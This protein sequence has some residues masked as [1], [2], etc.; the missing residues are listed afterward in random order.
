MGTGTSGIAAIAMVL[1][2]LGAQIGVLSFPTT[3][4]DLRSVVVTGGGHVVICNHYNGEQF[5]VDV[6]VPTAPQLVATIDPPFGDQWYEAEYTP[7]FG[8]RL[9]SGHRGGGLNMVDTSNPFAPTIAASVSTIYHF[10]GLRYRNHGGQPMLYYAEK[11]M[12]LAAYSVGANSLS[13]VWTDFVNATNDADGMEIVGNYLHLFGSPYVQ[14]GR[15][16]LK[17]YDLTV[18][19][20]PQLVHLNSNW[21]VA[22]V[23][24]NHCQLRVTGLSSHLLA[25]RHDDGLDLVDLSNPAAPVSTTL[26]PPIPGVYC[27]GSFSVPGTTESIVYGVLVSGTVRIPMWYSF[28]V[29]PGF[30]IVPI[31]GG[32]APIEIFDMAVEPASGR[33]LVLGRDA[34]T[35]QGRLV[36]Y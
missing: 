31:A 6:S 17:T 28:H 27:W 12:G 13:L 24:Q 11:N 5:V 21:K 25:A 2:N 18:P 14:W 8:G 23:A 26:L 35:L 29:V 32:V 19:S 3:N 34:T 20:A 16:E 7:D 10:R 15:R 36:V 22:A 4:V 30:G 9:F 33:I 1:G